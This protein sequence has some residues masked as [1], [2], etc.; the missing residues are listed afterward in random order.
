MGFSK[1]KSKNRAKG[2]Q[3]VGA[4]AK[5]K[6]KKKRQIQGR[7]KVKASKRKAAEITS[8]GK[9]K[10]SVADDDALDGLDAVDKLFADEAFGDEDEEEE[11]VGREAPSDS[12]GSSAGAFHDV[13][14]DDDDGLP[15]DDIDGLDD[16]LG[17]GA[18]HEEE[19]R[20]IKEAD[21]QFYKFLVENDRALLDF[22]A[23]DEEGEGDEAAGAEAG[24]AEDGQAAP[25]GEKAQQVAQQGRILTLERFRRLQETVHDSFTAVKA[26]MNCFHLAVRSIEERQP[27]AENEGDDDGDGK[28]KKKRGGKKAKKKERQTL[29]R[30]DD[31]ATFS[32]VLEWS[33]ANM[34][35]LLRHHAGELQPRPSQ[36]ASGKKGQKRQ[37]TAVQ[38]EG[39]ESGVVDPTC[40]SRWNRVKV[41]AQIFWE[42]TFFLLSHLT[43]PQMLEYV[44]RTGSTPESLAWLWPFK[45][46]RQRYLRKCCSLWSVA[47][48]HKVRLL[49]FLFIRNSAAMSLHMPD[50]REKD[51]P[52]LELLI[53]MLIK[54]F[55]DVA[56]MG[57]SWRSLSTFRFMENCLLELLRI[58]DAT[59]YRIGYACIRQLALILRNAFVATSQSTEKSKKKKSAQT[60][61]IALV[62][63][64]FIRAIYLWTKAVGSVAAL[65]P[66]AY[67]LSM[68]VM[69]ATKTRLTSLQN[70]PFVHHCIRCLNRLGS[71]LEQFVPVSSYLLKAFSVLLQSM[72]KAHRKRG[73]QGGGSQGISGSKAPELE[74]ILR[75]SDGQ[76]SEVLALE[77]VGSSICFLLTDHLG[78]LSRSPAFP[79][80]VAPVLLHLKKFGKHCRSEPLRRQLKVMQAAIETSTSDVCAQREALT[81]VPSW[82]KFLMFEGVTA[83]AKTRA[84]TLQRK[85]SEERARVEAEMS[86]AAQPT[87]G[88]K[89]KEG[90]TANE[91]SKKAKKREKQKEKRRL[92]KE[93]LKNQ[94]VEAPPLGKSKTDVVEEMEFSSGE[95]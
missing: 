2:E 39:S 6:A 16:Q 44:L 66:L 7:E 62:G 93:T 57:Y 84:E 36:A 49:A 59:A 53:K 88:A 80:I 81:E 47:S 55:A 86:E 33:I 15:Q 75:F 87:K 92:E 20:K 67:P 34:V 17:A 26:A 21:P 31:E 27:D 38:P 76:L 89:D 56:V 37:K 25:S 82:K 91:K 19:L 22:R 90:Q 14:D 45:G 40:Y 12:E 68:I 41:L 94:K 28:K 8:Q 72:E 74:V 43:D 54:S 35:G 3:R 85:A 42:E 30:I 11:G 29:I 58:N 60:K 63:W 70:Y 23:P 77:A 50:S 5:E 71:S 9:S 65:K 10:R 46:L 52:Q 4:K 69:G 51:V 32:E 78:L 1:K 79:E 64:P 13:G 61:A 83:L 18:R 95:D 48:A 24:G 73:L